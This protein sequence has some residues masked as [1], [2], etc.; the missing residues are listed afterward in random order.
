MKRKPLTLALQ[1]QARRRITRLRA[2]GRPPQSVLDRRDRALQLMLGVLQA[3]FVDRS[4][5]LRAYKRHHDVH[6]P[7]CTTHPKP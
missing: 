5:L 2:R 7:G 3:A 6:H 1:Q 4:Q